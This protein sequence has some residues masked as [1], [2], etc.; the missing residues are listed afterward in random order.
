[1]WCGVWVWVE[2]ITVTVS[3]LLHCPA[4]P[5]VPVVRVPCSWWP[6]VCCRLILSRY[7]HTLCLDI[8]Y[9]LYLYQD[10]YTPCI[11]VSLLSSR[12]YKKKYDEIFG[13]ERILCC[14]CVDIVDKMSDEMTLTA[15][16]FLFTRPVVRPVSSEWC[17]HWPGHNLDS[18]HQTSDTSLMFR[19]L[20]QI[21]SYGQV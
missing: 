3:N 12:L 10:I 8:R 19:I 11:N 20:I 15:P 21:K 9:T 13:H 17:R 7:L 4:A 1:M 2:D 14:R 18:P 16:K 5:A 6:T